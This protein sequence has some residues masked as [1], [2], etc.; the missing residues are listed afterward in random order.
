M[1]QWGNYLFIFLLCLGLVACGTAAKQSDG[2]AGQPKEKEDI[3]LEMT[4]ESYPISAE[5]LDFEVI[6]ETGETYSV[7]LIP[8]LEQQLQDGN[9][10]VLDCIAGF[11]GVGDPLPESLSGSLETAWYPDLQPG[12]YRLSYTVQLDENSQRTVSAMFTLTA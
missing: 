10:Q 8:V 12:V 1:K 7:A 9:W 6:N 4:Q 2:E 5:Q 3:R 11:C